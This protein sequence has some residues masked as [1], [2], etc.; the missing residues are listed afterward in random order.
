MQADA[1]RRMTTQPPEPLPSNLVPIRGEDFGFEEARHL[2]LRAGF[3]G[4][5]RQIQTL[6]EWGPERAVDH[7]LDVDDIPFDDPSRDTFDPGIMR[8]PTE[9]ER[10]E[11]RRA[12]REQDEDTLA[13]LRA[14]RQ[15]RQRRDRRQ[16]R[17]IQR[18]WLERMIETPRPLEEK[19][20]LFWHGHF[21]TSY[22]KIED[23]YHMFQQNMLFRSQAI[24]SFAGLM[25]G[26]IRDPAMI[27]YLDNQRSRKQRPNENLA[28]ELMELFG[29]GEGNYTERDIKEGARAL[30]GYSFEDDAFVFRDRQHD[31]GVKRILGKRGRLDGA[32]FVTAILESPACAEFI[33]AKLYDFFALHLGDGAVSEPRAVSRA[34]S[35]M[36]DDLRRHEYDVKPA[37]RRLFLSRHFYHPGV[38]AS[39][40]K[41]PAELVVGGVRS[42]GAP[43]RDMSVLIQGME[44]MGQHLFAPPSVAGWATG[45][46]WINTST[47]YVRQ[48]ML[49]YML[50]GRMTRAFPAGG[51]SD[52][53][54]PAPLLAPLEEAGPM[55]VTDHEAVIDYLLRFTLG[56]S[57]DEGRRVLEEFA[58]QH[59]A[60]GRPLGDEVLTGIVLLIT[61][62]P[63]YQ[64]C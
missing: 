25:Y 29:L 9:A 56:W 39:R 40:I 41:S 49:N 28:R 63:E 5:P 11:Y 59:A 43:V 37:L 14:M 44:L 2:L 15:G 22:R 7:L 23:S 17:E 12:R 32:G 48:N 64:L 57:P 8:P 42:L 6:A 60:S 18:W 19:M 38:T 16:M 4:T 31:D 21:A 26:I 62:M 24:G 33:A 45:R 20:T 51:G 54:D 13:R 34:I 55:A 10:R 61:A 27:A 52:R 58:A 35:L 53:F 47:L 50:T 1:A 3:G 30:T 46:A 36:A